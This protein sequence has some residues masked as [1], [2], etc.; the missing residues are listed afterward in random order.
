M[1]P[2]EARQ[3]RGA[4]V[5]TA[6]VTLASVVAALVLSGPRAAFGS[7][8]AGL[9]VG[10]FFGADLLVSFWGRR[11][12]PSAVMALVLLTYTVKI[13][14]LGVVL[15][16]FQK[17][18]PFDPTWFAATIALATVTW[19]AAAVHTFTRLRLLTIE[20]VPDPLPEPVPSSPE[21]SAMGSARG[22]G[23]VLRR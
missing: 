19:L 2:T 16:L 11:S 23:D 6:A 1:H 17:A 7:A 10:A 14:A 12:A 9:V 15:A 21:G 20:P 4:G 13:V 22:E 5:P 8:L 18:A 3:L